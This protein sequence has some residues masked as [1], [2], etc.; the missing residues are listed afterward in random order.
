MSNTVV[1]KVIE[2]L[3]TLP[4]SQQQQVLAFVEALRTAV[5]P[6]IPGKQL[7]RFVGAISLQCSEGVAKKVIDNYAASAELTKYTPYK[8]YR[9]FDEPSLPE[10]FD[11]EDLEEMETD[12][13][14]PQME[15]D[16]SNP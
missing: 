12:S 8:E 15:T 2:Q 16:S 9:L 5:R 13:F 3:E 6:G 10:E 11:L 14:Q 7:L 4:E 1:G